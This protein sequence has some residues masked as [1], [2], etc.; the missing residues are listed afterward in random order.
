MDLICQNGSILEEILS[1]F[2][3]QFVQGL[4]DGHAQTI[5][6]G[7]I[8][9]QNI[10]IDHCGRP[11]LA[12]FG[13]NFKSDLTNYRFKFSDRESLPPRRFSVVLPTI[14]FVQTYGL[15]VLR[16]TG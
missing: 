12:D 10:L 15:L 3:C 1:G 7:D 4:N 2:C 16:F 9:R 8:K 13:L 14:P 5:V 6:G 11:N